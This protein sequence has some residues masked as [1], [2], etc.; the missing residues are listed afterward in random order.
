MAIVRILEDHCKSCGVCVEA[1]PR[2]ALR[3][4]TR[5]NAHGFNSVE[6][7]ATKG[8]TGCGMCALV[9]PDA[10]IELYAPAKTGPNEC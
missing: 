9:C 7:D 8:C 6:F 2:Q 4:G 5:L 3:I 10:A 1:C